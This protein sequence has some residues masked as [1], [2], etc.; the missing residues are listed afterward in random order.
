MRNIWWSVLAVCLWG[1]PLH[2]V[3][4]QV[5][6]V[7]ITDQRNVRASTTRTFS[8]TDTVWL[9]FHVTDFAMDQQRR[10]HIIENLVI[11]DAQKQVVASVPN[12]L[13][14][15]QV[16]EPGTDLFEVENHV[17]LRV[18]KDRL[19]P[20]EYYIVA[21]FV[22]QLTRDEKI[23]SHKITIVATRS[24]PADRAPADRPSTPPNRSKTSIVRASDQF[25]YGRIIYVTGPDGEPRMLALYRPGETIWLAVEVEGYGMRAGDGR[26]HLVQDLYVYDP[27]GEKILEKPGIV[28]FRDRG[29]K[30]RPVVF[31]L[32]ITLR[33]PREGTYT[34]H[35]TTTDRLT[36]ERIETK[37]TFRMIVP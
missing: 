3:A 13:K 9:F 4:L 18:L 32:Q 23:V 6:A 15:Q 31:T 24:S 11:I 27:N 1:Y 8:L 20:G 19:K 5:Q 34:I 30:G 26:A 10:C 37:T 21:Q 17:Q 35:L 29:R 14:I 16:V 2:A 22:D 28:T 36:G 25:K 12:L 7:N 33:D